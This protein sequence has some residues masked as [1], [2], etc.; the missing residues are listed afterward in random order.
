VRGRGRNVDDRHGVTSFL[1]ARQLNALVAFELAPHGPIADGANLDNFDLTVQQLKLKFGK[2]AGSDS[3]ALVAEAALP[4]G[5]GLDLTNETA[6][7]SIGIPAGERMTIVERILPPGSFVAHGS[8]YRFAD[9]HGEVADGL[10]GVTVKVRGTRVTMKAVM[11]KTD[12]TVLRVPNPDL[13]IALEVGTR[14]L[15]S[16]RRYATNGKGTTTKLPKGK[17]G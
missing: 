5:T 7:L 3:L 6:I 2:R 4:T 8:T 15:A 9:R 1:S 16:T 12:L 17:R 11:K 10:R 14:T 13:T